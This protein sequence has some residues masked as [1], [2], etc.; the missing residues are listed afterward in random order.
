MIFQLGDTLVAD[1][2]FVG[3]GHGG[4]LRERIAYPGAIKVG[5]HP[6]D[7]EWHD[8]GGRDWIASEDGTYTIAIAMDY[9]SQPV[10]YQLDVAV[11]R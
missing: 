5:S 2:A 7:A 1:L 11:H 9:G 10:Q 8:L 3:D 4:Q 6:E